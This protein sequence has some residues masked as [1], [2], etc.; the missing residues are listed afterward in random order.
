MA[1]SCN[2][3]KYLRP[4]YC[5]SAI[6]GKLPYPLEHATNKMQDIWV[7][8]SDE[9]FI[10]FDRCFLIFI[11]HY[12]YVTIS[13]MA[14]QITGIW[15][16]RSVLCSGAHQRKHQSSASLAFV[17]GIHQCPVDSPQNSNVESIS[18]W[19]RHHDFFGMC[20]WGDPMGWSNRRQA[21]TW[22]LKSSL[23]QW[24]DTTP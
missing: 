18:I 23:M 21:I 14:S 10:S 17:R 13:V 9:I 22:T 16:V 1:R 6:W 7:F 2:P 24:G 12:S 11:E 5:W 4:P 8:I 15:T 3:W 20:S 19:W